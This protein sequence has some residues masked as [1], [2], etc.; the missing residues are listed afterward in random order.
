MTPARKSIKNILERA[1]RKCT[2]FSVDSVHAYCTSQEYVVLCW[3]FDAK[4]RDL[5]HYINLVKKG[6][7]Y[8]CT[9]YIHVK[10]WKGCVFPKNRYFINIY[11]GSPE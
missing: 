10:N 4:P 9:H 2:Q 6:D 5:D 3:Y 7:S 1:L 8:P 11:M